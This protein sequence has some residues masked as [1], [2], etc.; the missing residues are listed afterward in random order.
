MSPFSSA[1]I[2][3]LTL[4]SYSTCAPD[5]HKWR[6]AYG[7]SDIDARMDRESFTDWPRS[8]TVTTIGGWQ[9]WGGRSK[10][11]TTFE[12]IKGPINHVC[13]HGM[14]AKAD[15]LDVLG[16]EDLWGPNGEITGELYCKQDQIYVAVKPISKTVYRVTCDGRGP[17]SD[18]LSPIIPSSQANLPVAHSLTIP[19]S[20]TNLLA[21]KSNGKLINSDFEN[22]FRSDDVDALIKEISDFASKAKDKDI[23]GDPKTIGKVLADVTGIYRH[24][25]INTSKFC[26]YFAKENNS[27]IRKLIKELYKCLADQGKTIGFPHGQSVGKPGTVNGLPCDDLKAFYEADEKCQEQSKSKDRSFDSS[28]CMDSRPKN[29]I[30][31]FMDH[32]V[33]SRAYMV[34]IGKGYPISQSQP[35][36]N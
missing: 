3:V 31:N 29:D 16:Q 33:R 27:E 25:D 10:E 13:T 7:I 6:T 34:C 2:A 35:H 36:Q 5:G 22:K 28:K 18:T 15:C 4:S 11:A 8:F 26:W 9:S 17:F 23:F 20:Q 24:G 1:L 30:Y 14:N 32:W 21:A 12:A 19:P